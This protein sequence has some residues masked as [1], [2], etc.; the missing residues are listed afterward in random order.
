MPGPFA[1]AAAARVARRVAVPIA[2]EAYRR[3]QSMSPEDKERYRA[4]MRDAAQRG[5]TTA[6]DLAARRR[7][8]PPPPPGTGV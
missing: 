8:E 5:R 4:R 1:A 2:R 3:W 6:N 7:R